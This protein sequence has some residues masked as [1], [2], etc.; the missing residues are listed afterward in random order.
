MEKLLDVKNLVVNFENKEKTTYAVNDVSFQVYKG[1][2]L[3]IVG[4]SGSG[5]SV[6]AKSIIRILD[7][8]SI[9]SGEILFK[10]EDILK[11]S[12]SQMKELRGEKISMV[13]QDPMTSLNPL[14][15]I[16]TQMKRLIKRHRR[17]MGKKQIEDLS[18]TWLDRVGIPDAKN[19]LSSYPHEFSGGMRQRVMIAM[20]LC[21]EAEMIIADE[22]TTALDVTIQSQVLDLLNNLSQ[23][24]TRS[25]ILITHDLGVVANNCDRVVVMYS[26]MIMEVG[27]VEDIFEKPKHPYTQGLLKSLPQKNS[28]ERLTPIKGNPPNMTLEIKGCPFQDRC[29][30]SMDRCREDLPNM[31]TF[32][33]D[34]RARCYL[35]EEE[36]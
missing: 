35:L 27:R 7:D 30:Y 21:L 24:K 12:E 14:F 29:E 36:D 16:G 34:H 18:I 32:S 26:G 13:F 1:E 9:K 17:S 31:V 22:P 2:S 10:G 5:K 20:A 33:K 8:K 11:K 25:V 19:R 15:T 6:T 28:K 23:E 3:G 4:E